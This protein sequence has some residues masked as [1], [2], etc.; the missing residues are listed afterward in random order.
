MALGCSQCQGFGLWTFLEDAAALGTRL[1]YP[2]HLVCNEFHVLSQIG[3]AD[4]S[5]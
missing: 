2:R 4:V 1:G 3:V 5:R